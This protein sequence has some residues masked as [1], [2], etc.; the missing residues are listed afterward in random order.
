MEQSL[1]ASPIEMTG[2]PY[3]YARV[4]TADQDLTVQR[5]A[6]LAAGVPEGLIFAE[7]ASGTTT[8]GRDE[9]ARLMVHLRP[10]KCCSSPGSTG[11]TVPA[12]L[13]PDRSR[14]EKPRHRLEVIQVDSGNGVDARQA[15]LSV[16]AVRGRPSAGS[17]ALGDRG[18]R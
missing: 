16:T 1:P 14:P 7:T 3:G 9:L 15:A 13:C 17:V 8:D 4:S 18:D 6:L 5:A 12:R 10:G 2:R 11:W